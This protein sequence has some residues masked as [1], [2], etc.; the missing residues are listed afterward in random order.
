MV[1]TSCLLGQSPATPLKLITNRPRFE[2]AEGDRKA[3]AAALVVHIPGCLL[4]VMDQL[5]WKGGLADDPAWV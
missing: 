2:R 1:S 4:R 5:S 3:A